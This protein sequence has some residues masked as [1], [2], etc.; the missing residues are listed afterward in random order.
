MSKHGLGKLP[1]WQRW[2]TISSFMLCSI[3]GIAFL[4]GHEFHIARPTLGTHSILVLHGVTSALALMAFGS[5]LPCHLKAGLKARKNLYSG[6][7]Q[8]A[9]L[10]I[11]IVTALLLYYGPE[12]WR[13]GSILMH[14]V[15]GLL[16]F[17]IF[18]LHSVFKKRLVRN[19]A[20]H[21]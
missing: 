11:L 14:W 21:E 5:I 20:Q 2:F 9:F 17:G 18:L 16:F 15:I 1:N 8:L 10:I 6:L 12:E 19:T 3:S 4:V 7:L 13:D